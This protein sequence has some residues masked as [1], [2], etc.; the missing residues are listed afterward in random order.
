[1]HRTISKIC[2]GQSQNCHVQLNTI[3][4][5]FGKTNNSVCPIEILVPN[6]I[7]ILIIFLRFS[8]IFY[9]NLLCFKAYLAVLRWSF[10]H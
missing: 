6:G 3:Q 9:F 10:L 5:N 7:L 4:S 2:R 1:M 8:L